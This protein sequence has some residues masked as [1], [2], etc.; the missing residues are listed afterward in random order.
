VERLSGF[1]RVTGCG[2]LPR[3]QLRRSREQI[4]FSNPRTLQPW[5]G[6]I[7]HRWLESRKAA[8]VGNPNQ[9]VTS[10]GYRKTLCQLQAEL[11]YV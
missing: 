10:E 4:A 1:M 7:Q 6:S 5:E 3:T 9:P 2:G 11:G 8:V